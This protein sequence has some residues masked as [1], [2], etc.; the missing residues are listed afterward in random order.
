MVIFTIGTYPLLGFCNAIIYGMTKERRKY[1]LEYGKQK[2]IYKA[3]NS[4]SDSS[5]ALT[6]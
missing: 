3:L 6:H 4:Y 5:E 2:S 1:L